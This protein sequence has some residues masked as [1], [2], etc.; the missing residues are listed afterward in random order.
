MET[1]PG[2]TGPKETID[3]ALQEF[4]LNDEL[5]EDL[6]MLSRSLLTS[7]A[8]KLERTSGFCLADLDPEL[9]E[10]CLA[11]NATDDASS[12]RESEPDS[13]M[14]DRADRA[15][16]AGAM[17]EVYANAD[18]S[19][20]EH[21]VHSTPLRAVESCREIPTTLAQHVLNV[22]RDSLVHD[23]YILQAA[24]A[25]NFPEDKRIVRFI[26]NRTKFTKRSKAYSFS[27][28]I[29]GD[30]TQSKKDRAGQ[31]IYRFSCHRKSQPY[32]D[33][34]Q[35]KGGKSGKPRVRQPSIRSGCKA[36]I[37]ATFRPKETSDGLPG[38]CYKVEYHFEHNHKLGFQENMDTVRKSDAIRRRIKTM[39]TREM[40]VH[41]IMNHLTADHARLTRLLEGDN[42]PTG[43]CDD[44]I[45]YKDV[46]NT[47][48]AIIAKEV[49][50]NPDDVKSAKL[51]MVELEK[52][53][54]L[55][56]YDKTH[57]RYFGFSSPWQLDQLRQWGDVLYF[58]GI[59]NVRGGDTYLFTI[60][61]R[62]KETGFG[63]PVAFLV[64]KHQQWELLKEWLAQLKAKLDLRCNKPYFPTA[65]ITDQ[66]ENEI[67]ALLKVFNFKTQVHADW[68]LAEPAEDILE[69]EHVPE[70]EH[71]E[72]EHVPE[73]DDVA[74]AERVC[75]AEHV[76]ET[77]HAPESEDIP[78]LRHA[79]EP[80][81]TVMKDDGEDL[82][83]II[84][85][86]TQRLKNMDPDKKI[87]NFDEIFN[88]LKRGLELLDAGLPVQTECAPRN[89][90]K[91]RSS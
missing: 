20:H 22:V 90:R 60:I 52:N 2:K 29:K 84:N 13:A 11:E 59:H 58:D 72:T 21:D 88:I 48:H 78:E 74:E 63:V 5:S 82:H 49:K 17:A 42:T 76:T 27:V 87:P 51:W 43:S 39:L 41:A 19:H 56:F 70:A 67:S 64:T 69:I 81:P 50:K 1:A 62:N 32:R 38:D 75:E 47:L 55:T 66:G 85:S 37:N 25:F 33:K 79:L 91:R 10:N 77:E 30:S 45:T 24:A 46:Y 68:L 14:T 31:I 36:A 18:N 6:L 28:D 80:D 3:W 83:S 65:V 16:A 53:N 89:K 23:E 71:V 7:F 61:V 12:D 40:S 44:F 35:V 54:Y 15:Q 34:N 86:F 26:N 8:E 9:I 4:N 57:G 73:V